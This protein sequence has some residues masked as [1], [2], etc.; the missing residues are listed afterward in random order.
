MAATKIL[1]RKAGIGWTTFVHT[2][3]PMP[4]SA[5]G[6]GQELFRGSYDNTDVHAKLRAAMGL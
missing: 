2:G 1:G 3:A 5:V 6:V 4:V